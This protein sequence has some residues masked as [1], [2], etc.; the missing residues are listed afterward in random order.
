MKF[1]IRGVLVLLFVCLGSCTHHVIGTLK[2]SYPMCEAVCKQRLSRCHE[3]C[4]N[5][6]FQCGAF[7]KQSTCKAYRHYQHEEYVKGG[8]ISRELNAYRDPLQCRKV[9]CDCKADYRICMQA[10]KGA[11]SKQLRSV[12]LCH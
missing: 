7:T 10:S 4:R 3:L 1:C 9:T 6:C 8:E 11:I 5:N 2:Q 12:P